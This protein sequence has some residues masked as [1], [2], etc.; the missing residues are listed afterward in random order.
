MRIIRF[1]LYIPNI[2]ERSRSFFNSL[3]KIMVFE[4]WIFEILGSITCD[5][6]MKKTHFYGTPAQCYNAFTALF[7]D[8]TE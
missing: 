4:Y 2:V 7:V 8:H 1:N 3:R 5:F 6:N